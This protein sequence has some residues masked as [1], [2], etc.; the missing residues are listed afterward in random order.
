MLLRFTLFAAF[1]A[2]GLGTLA[3][4]AFRPTAACVDQINV[5]VDGNCV[6]TITPAMIDAGGNSPCGR[7]PKTLSSRR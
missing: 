5:A 3:A 7:A 4:N 6:G 2:L 1:F